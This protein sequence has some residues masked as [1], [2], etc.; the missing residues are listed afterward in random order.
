MASTSG[1]LALIRLGQRDFKAAK[2]YLDEAGPHYEATL[3]ANSRHP[4]YRQCCRSNLTALI[5]AN[6]GLVDQ[7]GAKQAAEKL[8]DLGWD[9]P[10]DAYQAASALSLCIP[11]VQSDNLATKDA[12]DK[13][14]AF[15]GD[16]AMKMLRHAVAKGYHDAAHDGQGQRPR[17]VAQREDFKKLLAE[18]KAKTN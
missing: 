11:I 3:K 4:D 16:E 14:A 6:A 15:Y 10:N 1:N 5:Q 17:P 7:A 18:L 13:Q 2:A 9:P 8:R 12:L